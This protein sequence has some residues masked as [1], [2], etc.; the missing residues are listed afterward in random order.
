MNPLSLLF[1]TSDFPARWH[2]G[3]WTDLHGW[4]HVIADVAIFGAYFAIPGVLIYFIRRRRDTPFLPIFWLFAAFILSCGLVHLVE[5][6]IFWHPW[7]RLSALIKVIT[8][9]ASWATVLALIKV[10]PIALRLPAIARL[11]A[12]LKSE[13]AERKRAEYALRASEERFSLAVAGSNDGIWDWHIPTGEDFFSERWCSLLG[14]GPGELEP[15]VSTWDNL[16]HPEDKESVR[17]AVTDHLEKRKPYD[18][19]LRMRTKSGEYR[20]YRARGQAIWNEEGTPVRMAGSLTDIHAQKQAEAHRKEALDTTKNLNAELEQRVEDRTKKLSSILE[21][22]EVLLQEVHHRVKNNLQVISSIINMQSR[23]LS[24]ET[25]RTAL[26][27]CQNRVQ[28]IALIHERIYQTKNYAEVSFSEY[29]RTLASGV[30][31]ASGTSPAG[32]RLELDIDELALPVGQAIPCGLILSELITNSLKHAFP[33]ERSGTIVVS[34][35]HHDDSQVSVVVQDD[36]VG[37]PELLNL[38]Q[39]KSLGLQIVSTLVDQLDGKLDMKVEEGTRE[40]GTRFEVTF[41]ILHR[42]MTKDSH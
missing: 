11:N 3:D 18:I 32:I 2:C 33:G 26:E 10:L 15:H 13:V 22:R 20:W 39:S 19:E 42:R 9:I 5:A 28:A 4:T 23:K 36:G 17:Q 25:A 16:V 27:D 8:A 1:D 12:Q 41:P 40:E 34:I 29:A 24:S 31:H 30:F 35:K 7:Y 14:F 38:G 6:T 21:E 37:A